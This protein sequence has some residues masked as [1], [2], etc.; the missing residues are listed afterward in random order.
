[1]TDKIEPVFIDQDIV[2]LYSSVLE[3]NLLS[4]ISEYKLHFGSPYCRFVREEKIEVGHKRKVRPRRYMKV[5]STLS[6]RFNYP[7]HHKSSG[8][9]TE[10]FG[11][12][13]FRKAT[14][15]H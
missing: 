13:E 8:S 12:F 1:M 9:A 14:Q 6:L 15:V 10:A 11:C 7:G 5:C 2:I 3:D 4:N